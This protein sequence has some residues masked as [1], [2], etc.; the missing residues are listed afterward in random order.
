MISF[1]KNICYRGKFELGKVISLCVE[2]NGLNSSKI[3]ENN[4]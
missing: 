3:I 1:L 4:G 2:V